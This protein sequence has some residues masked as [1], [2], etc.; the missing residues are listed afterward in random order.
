[1]QTARSMLL[2]SLDIISTGLI[3]NTSLKFMRKAI[4]DKFAQDTGVLM[5]SKVFSAVLSFVQGIYVASILGPKQYGVALLIIGVPTLFFKT[6]D[7]RTSAAVVMFI[8][9]FQSEKKHKCVLAMCKLGYF[10]DFGIATLTIFL[11]ILLSSWA[12]KHIVHESGVAGLMII[13]STIYAAK[14][15]EGTSIAVLSVIGR[16]K[17]IAITEIITRLFG[18]AA[19]LGFVLMGWGVKGVVFGRM[20]EFGLLGIGVSLWAFIFIKRMWGKFWFKAKLHHLA[21]YRRKIIKYLV[22]SELNE[23][24]GTITKEADLLILGALGGATEAGFYGLAKRLTG[25]VHLIVDPL[26]KVVLPKISKLW[27]EHDFIRLR[28]QIKIY[29]KMIGIPLGILTIFTLPFIGIF[30]RHVVGNEYAPAVIV[31]Q[32]FLLGASFWLMCFWVRPLFFAMSRVKALFV[33]SI[34]QNSI[35]L[36]GYYLVAKQWGAFG[37]AGA[38]VIAG[39]ITL[40]M[41]LVYCINIIKTCDDTVQS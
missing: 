17:H 9:Q 24:I 15:L 18:F 12:E 41:Q 38:S 7:A 30:I 25:S 20:V 29:L 32:I 1:M 13:F 8:S 19:V 34:I 35:A 10:I 40:G 36:I 6:V 11:V 5:L 3:W 14:S 26:Q 23:L 33:F 2:K 4:R 31:T 39:S 16:F 37:M 22:Y 28:I 27:A 21:V